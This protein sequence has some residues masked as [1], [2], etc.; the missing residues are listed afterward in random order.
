MA[1]QTSH[2]EAIQALPGDTPGEKYKWISDLIKER[3]SESNSLEEVIESE[4]IPRP[5][6]PFVQIHAAMMLNKKNPNDQSTYAAIAEALKSRDEIIVNKALQANNFFNGT[7]E[8]ITNVQ[9][10]FN[11]LFPYV[12]LN[13]RTRIINV[14][15]SRLASKNPALA[16]EFFKAVASFY[17]LKQA[18]P[19]LPACSESFMYNVIVEKRI[20]L[21]R[22]LI[23][24]IFRKNPDFIVR[25]FKLTE[26]SNDPCE[27]R[28]HPI[29]IYKLS[30]FLPK[31]IKKRLDSFVELYEM[32]EPRVTLSNLCA[33]AFLKNGKEHLQQKPK[34]YIKIL[35]LKRISNN[36]MEIIFPKL[37]PT[38][39]DN[40]DTDTM[41]DY[42]EYYR[43]DKKLDFFLK[44]YK[45]VYGKNILDDSSKVTATLLKMLPVKERVKQARIKLQ[46]DDSTE[47]RMDYTICWKCYLPI[48][49]SI[50]Q[51]KEQINTTSEMEYRSALVCNMIYSCKVNN[52]DQALLE[53]MMYIKIRH[54]NE[55]GLFLMNV[56]E[57]LL[58]LYDL[59]QMGENFWSILM[60]IIMRA[61]VK[62]DLNIRNTT[63][64]RIVEAA[65]HYK[66]LQSQPIYQMIEIF[67]ELKMMSYMDNWNILEKYSEYE[68]T[69]L[70]ICITI[71]SQKYDSDQ[72]PWKWNKAEMVYNLCSSIYHFNDTHVNKT[73]RVERMS[74]KNY[75]WLMEKVKEIFS[76]NDEKRDQYVIDNLKRILS[77]HEQDLYESLAVE[78]IA[79][80]SKGEALK[81]LKRNPEKI[82]ARW[83]EYLDGCRIS[84]TEHTMRFLKASRWYNE[85]PIKFVEQSLD[86]LAKKKK[87][88]K[89]LVNLVDGDTFSRIVEPFI[90]THK[91]IDV[92]NEEARTNYKLVKHIIHCMIL[93]NPPVPLTLLTKLF[94]GD[95]LSV[96]LAALINVC[97][98]TNAMDTISF[99][100]T[101]ASQRVSVR[102]HGIRLMRMLAPRDQLI[103]FLQAQWEIE[104]NH[105]VREVLFTESMELFSDDPES[106]TWS[107]LASLISMLTPKDEHLFS[108]KLFSLI[109]LTPNEYVADFMKLAL[110]TID[111][112]AGAGEIGKGKIAH[113]VKS[114][115]SSIDAGICNLLSEEFFE[116]LARRFFFHQDSEI[117]SCAIKYVVGN[118]LRLPADKFDA[119]MKI[120][121]NVLKEIVKSGWDV[122][123]PENSCYYPVNE[124]VCR[125]I[126]D[127]VH[128]SYSFQPSAIKYQLI[129]GILSTFLTVLTPE[130]DTKS[131]LMLVFAREQISSKTPKEFGMNLG[132]RIVELIEMFSILFIF[133]MTDILCNMLSE[134][135][136][137]QEYNNNYDTIDI[138]LEVMEG[139]IEIGSMEAGIVAAKLSGTI[140][141][142]ECSE[143]YNELMIKLSKYNDPVIKGIVCSIINRKKF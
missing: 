93:A 4:K 66:I 90:P 69:C 103:N 96:A 3:L 35:P 109:K 81:I 127:V 102:K 112:F 26:Q 110:Y 64:V 28:L 134:V 41:L 58:E 79:N 132:Q 139:L 108:N 136:L 117:S 46:R 43:Q 115:L 71:A 10:F 45:Q 126:D 88:C 118:M 57:T 54:K 21:T 120:T 83:R 85:I 38:N 62:G 140:A 138:K 8:Y 91:S 9:Y 123:H 77:R 70:E 20:V 67:M 50:P 31:L 111:K 11:Y 137:F 6:V 25:Y 59:P 105:S 141:L 114:F 97:R 82:L 27:R 116:Q 119:L 74:I 56:F 1:V 5:L 12:S 124:I 40:F 60:D 121:C 130:T 76:A 72:Q 37:F 125:F 87:V 17:G 13:T 15:A 143:R 99:A 23:K 129:D 33:E 68:R 142:D 133:Y 122:P 89:I 16:E 52:D 42:L 101:L 131:Y 34:L 39:V 100:R 19:L 113:Y 65:I 106:V 53:T 135:N 92:E 30:D 86:D 61:H 95:Y 48:N 98:R 84:Y 7:N 80:V 75:P 14:L 29:N 63:G 49:E 32:F 18:L 55:Q 51:L 22:K 107:H 36:C 73:Y 2:L 78:E 104:E 128:H 47:D 44:S 94:E 24:Q